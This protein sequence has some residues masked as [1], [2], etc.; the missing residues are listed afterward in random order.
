M[1]SRS[2]FLTVLLCVFLVL[3]LTS[4]EK[5]NISADIRVDLTQGVQN[6]DPQFA[7]DPV[8][9][10]LITNT[11]EGLLRKEQDGSLAPGVAESYTVSPD[12]LRYSFLLRGDAKW[13]NGEPVTAGDFVFALRRLFNSQVPSPYAEEYLAIQNAPEILKGILSPETLGVIAKDD[14]TL[15]IRLSTASPLFV[16][17]LAGTPAMPC[18]QAFFTSTRARYGLAADYL[19]Y[20]GAYAVDKW[21]NAKSIS[22]Q[23]NQHYWEGAKVVC[24]KVVF[25]T[26]R[27]ITP[28]KATE[29]DKAKSAWELFAEKKT[30][31][32]PATAAELEKVK[33]TDATL[34]EIANRGYNL[35]A[36]TRQGTLSNE[37]VRRAM[38]LALDRTGFRERTPAL[39]GISDNLVPGSARSAASGAQNLSPWADGNSREYAQRGLAELGDSQIESMALLIPTETDLSA[40]GAYLQRQWKDVLG[41]YVNLDLQPQAEFDKKL[42]AGDFSFAL[43]PTQATTQDPA[44]VLE[45]YAT[46]SARNYSGWSSTAFDNLLAAAAAAESETLATQR[47][48]EAQQMVID[49]GV[50]IPVLTQSSYYAFGKGVTGIQLTGGMLNLREASRTT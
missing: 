17:R 28:E 30:D 6:L 26:S 5:K 13:S 31:I 42:A 34:Q 39:Y 3:G 36:N 24:P 46:G 10:M 15:E 4:C 27:I 11:F 16:Q 22:L 32:Y 35:V 2:F 47:Y 37:N 19:L 20:N 33:A 12:G 18:N 43:V 38:M 50:A 44:G 8:A 21:D 40:L 23:K 48:D 1:S 29:K 45:A 25:Y 9:C 49:S 41:V 14:K 7:T